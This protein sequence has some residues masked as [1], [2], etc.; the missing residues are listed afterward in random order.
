LG[1]D[2]CPSPGRRGFGGRRKRIGCGQ[3]SGVGVGRRP[4]LLFV[5]V[6]RLDGGGSCAG[7]NW[8]WSAE[9]VCRQADRWRPGPGE[10]LRCPLR[11]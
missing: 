9:R 2:A 11:T 1:Q 4:R 7:R 10:R 8:G 3:G 6:L 5:A